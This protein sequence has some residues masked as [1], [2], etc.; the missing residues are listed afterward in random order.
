M[1]RMRLIVLEG[2][3][4][5]P[6]LLNFMTSHLR[7]VT[8]NFPPSII[9]KINKNYI[10]ILNKTYFDSGH[11][12]GIVFLM[13]RIGLRFVRLLLNNRTIS[14]QT[15]AMGLNLSCVEMQTSPHCVVWTHGMW[16]QRGVK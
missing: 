2:D 11:L 12:G 13:V 5:S 3:I 7:D 1:L 8:I 9:P 6:S 14:D 10:H 4:R 15:G 16:L